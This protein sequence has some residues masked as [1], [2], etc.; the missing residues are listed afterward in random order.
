MGHTILLTFWYPK[1]LF[2]RVSFFRFKTNVWKNNWVQSPRN[3][4]RI[5][6][7]W[8]LSPVM[9]HPE[10]LTGS[11]LWTDIHNRRLSNINRIHIFNIE[12]CTY[13]CSISVLKIIIAY[14]E[15]FTN[16]RFIWLILVIKYHCD[17]DHVY[18]I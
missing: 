2:L 15:R 14:Y 17:S 10:K 5:Q 9:R 7:C 13:V 16:I 4:I 1:L 11:V 3:W 6:M 12:T 18:S 8:S